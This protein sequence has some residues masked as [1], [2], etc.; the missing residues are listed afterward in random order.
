MNP[1]LQR[2]AALGALFS[3][4]LVGIS[5]LPLI[6]LS[7]DARESLIV[8]APLALL[9]AVGVLHQ[10]CRRYRP[11]ASRVVM[12]I[13]LTGTLALP[14]LFALNALPILGP[15]LSRYL[16]PAFSLV[17]VA[18]SAVWMVLAAILGWHTRVLPLLLVVAGVLSGATWMFLLGSPLLIQL[19]PLPVRQVLNVNIAI[20]LLSY[21][22]WTVGLGIWLLWRPAMPGQP[23]GVSVGSG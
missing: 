2:T 22:S 16:M 9:P 7:E 3:M 20:W 18:L 10:Q 8:L 6:N 1:W 14:I 19:L 23:N 21:T 15:L 11:R 12:G 5:W 17:L 13:G 4:L